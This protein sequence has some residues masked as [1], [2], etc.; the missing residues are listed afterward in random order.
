MAIQKITGDVIATSAVTADSLADTTITAAKLHTT[1]DLT[2]KTVTVSTASAGDNDTTVASTAFVSTAVSNLVD[3]SP[4]ALNTLNELAAALGDDANFSTTVTNSIALK[5]PLASP[6]FTGTITGPHIVSTSNT[7]TQFKNA[8]DTDIQHKF[9]TNAGSDFAIH[10]LIGSDGVD[11]K[12]IIGYGPNHPS[13]SNHMA[14]K[15]S[16]ASGSIGFN[17][18]SSSIERIHI[19]SSGNVGIGNSSPAAYG[20]FVVQGTATQLALNASSGKARVGFFENGQGRFYIDT[21]N[22]S[23]GLAFVDADGSSERMRIDSSG[24]ITVNN[25]I[26]KGM[27]HLEIKNDYGTDGTATSPRLFSPASGTLAFSANGAERMRITSAGRISLSDSEG[28][29]LS[30]KTSG[31]YALDGALSYYGTNNGVYLNGAGTDG[32]LRLNA[33]G[34][35]NNRTAI[36]LYGQNQGDYIKMRAG[37]TDALWINS[38]GNVGIGESSP[39]TSLHIKKNQSSANS[40]IKLENSAGGNNSSFSIDWQLASSGT[41]A[42]IKA[43]RTNSPGA[44]DTDLIFSTSTTGTALVEA[45]RIDQSGNIGIGTDNPSSKLNVVGGAADAGI[46]IKSGGNSGVHPF[47]VT[48]TNGTEGDMFIV[49]D[50]GNVGIGATTPNNMSHTQN[51]SITATQSTGNSW[52]TPSSGGNYSVLGAIEASGIRN[53]HVAKWA[54]SGNLSANNWYPFTKRSQLQALTNDTGSN[55]EEGFGMYFRI[56]TYTSSSGYGEYF[57]NRVTSTIWVTNNGSNSNQAHELYVGPGWGHA[58]NGGHDPDS[59][60]SCPLRMRVAHHHGSDSTWPADITVEIRCAG[61]LSGLNS[62][63]AGRQLMIYGYII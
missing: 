48:W 6:T 19:D 52:S 51:N 45:M 41:S 36:D 3:S 35:S 58:P 1:L 25:G 14:L 50:N 8:T 7:A 29:K 26:L 43:D 57:S 53:R 23:D 2:G 44:G 22:G 11:N 27:S 30:A 12:F 32:W 55:S 15:N 39:D 37:N 20:K 31:M 47:R 17:T 54:F 59:A 10:R 56:Y 42:Q 38:A 28:I 16:H 33:S 46:S 5:A 61:A 60:T 62:A 63:V 21:L 18:G 40:S 9:E 49:D 4:D 13:T 34:V 24:D